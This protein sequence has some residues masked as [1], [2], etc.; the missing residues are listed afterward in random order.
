MDNSRETHL[1]QGTIIKE[2]YQI[3]DTIGRGGFCYT[4]QAYDNLL[5]IYVAI[6]E[7]FPHGVASREYGTTVM[8]YTHADSVAF[9]QGKKRFL[10]E[11][12]GLAVFNSIPEIVS[13]YD[14]FDSNGTAYIVM[15]YLKGQNLKEYCAGV[16]SR[17]PY[18]FV[19]HMAYKL[20]SVLSVVHLQGIIHRDISPDN[21][22]LCDDGT[23]KLI[24]FG[25]LTQEVKDVQGTMTII[26]KHGF[27]PVEQYYGNGKI[28]PWT[29]VYALG[30]T[31]YFLLT[32]RM[33]QDSVER[34]VQDRMEP[35]HLL[36]PEIPYDY[37][38]AIM[39]AMSIDL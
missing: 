23:L 18:E 38:M 14:F 20:C 32:G 11:A 6:K 26:V 37:S 16:G 24:D 5:G 17:L 2:R 27:A 33:P 31:L 34:I 35:P 12:R 10:K 8:V 29:D 13:V 19:Y 3:C 7:Y 21:I 28:G 4:Y 39:K 9:E 1:R 25:A 30:A 15:E 22:F 36:N